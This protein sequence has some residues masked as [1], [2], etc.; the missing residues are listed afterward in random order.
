[1][2]YRMIDGLVAIGHSFYM[3]DDVLYLQVTCGVGLNNSFIRFVLVLYGGIGVWGVVVRL[4]IYFDGSSEQWAICVVP[5]SV[6]CNSTIVLAG[7]CAPP[8]VAR[9]AQAIFSH[10]CT[11]PGRSICKN[12]GMMQQGAYRG[13]DSALYLKHCTKHRTILIH[14]RGF[15]L[16][17]QKSALY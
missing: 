10:N 14:D 9:N 8:T 4:D 15:A 16:Y 2:S 13:Q 1:M 11:V 12:T 3:A 5:C 6:I 17:R 7:T